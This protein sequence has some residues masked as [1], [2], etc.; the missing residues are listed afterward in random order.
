MPPDHPVPRTRGKDGPAAPVER[1]AWTQVALR[2]G[3][4]S[5]RRIGS[6]TRVTHLQDADHPDRC[7]VAIL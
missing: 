4:H 2:P 6:V 5:A 7:A 1:A 3:A